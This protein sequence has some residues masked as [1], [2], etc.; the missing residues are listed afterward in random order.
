[1]NRWE[2]FEG[3]FIMYTFLKEHGQVYIFG[4][5]SRA[6]TLT[7]YLR[8]LYPDISIE[9]YLVD[10]L[11]E[12]ESAVDKLP[13]YGL[14]A[15]LP[16][17]TEIPVFIATKGIYHKAIELK[18]RRLGFKNIIP[19]TPEVDN[20]FRNAYVEAAFAKENRTFQKIDRLPTTAL[21]KQ[22]AEKPTVCIY[23]AKSV[24]DKPLQSP[25]SLPD[26]EKPIHVG[27]GL[28]SQ[29]PEGC[30]LRDCEGDNISDKNRQYCELTALYWIW[31]HAPEK[32][33]GLSHYRRHFILPEDWAE[34]MNDYDVDVIL[35]VPTYVAPNIADNYKERHDA[36]DWEYLMRYLERHLP[37]DFELAKTVFSGNLYSPCNM[38]IAKK[39]ISDELCDWLF[40]ILDAV[41][42]HGGVKT[43][44]YLNRY[45]GFISERLL[46]LFYYKNRERLHIVY[47]DKTFLQ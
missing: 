32:V 11:A 44:T 37:E 45:P 16:L 36:S 35:P 5:Q 20:Q 12:N 8:L 15:S 9:A 26:Y 6:K 4:A 2:H 25:D 14:D 21:H 40:P 41:V 18:L 28:T 7:G 24:Y 19:V 10:D 39:E 23:M 31:K 42:E 30:A 46:T 34:L 43:D 17:R 29:S 27:A 3:D 47:A 38:F 33:V 1:M 22:G 13:V